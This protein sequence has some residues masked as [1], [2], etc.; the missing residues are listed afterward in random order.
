M[1]TAFIRQFALLLVGSVTMASAQGQEASPTRPSVIG[2]TY[3]VVVPQHSWAETVHLYEDN[4]RLKW[5]ESLKPDEKAK[6]DGVKDIVSSYSLD[7]ENVIFVQYAVPIAPN[8]P[9]SLQVGDSLGHNYVVP[10]PSEREAEK[11]AEYV[12]RKSPLR[13]ELIGRAWRVRKPFQ[14][15]QDGKLGCRDFKELLDHGDPEITEYFYS[16]DPTTHTYACFRDKQSFFILQYTHLGESGGFQLEEFQ[17]QQTQN[18]RSGAG[19]K[20]VSYVRPNL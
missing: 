9:P 15:P 18:G 14:C 17:N 10:L 16:R 19:Y 20:M 1:K 6:A 12:A 8:V 11:F 5:D 7:Y 2:S 4:G 13:L 3:Y